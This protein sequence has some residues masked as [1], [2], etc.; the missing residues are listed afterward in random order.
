[1]SG[2]FDGFHDRVERAYQILR[3][4][5]TAFL[6][7][8][9]PQEQILGEAE[10]L[11]H[12]MTELKM[13]LKGV[14]FNRTHLECSM[15]RGLRGIERGDRAGADDLTAIRGIVDRALA[16]EGCEADDPEGAKALAEN[17]LRYQTIARGESLRMEA[18]TRGLRRGVPTTRVP[19]FPYDLHDIA[20]LAAM[21][22][23]LFAT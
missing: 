21:H 17:F 13:P 18:F 14:I 20:A 3:G 1:M 15:P 8:T 6:L 11:S 4:K 2:M 23:H 19:N 7:V 12:K 22:A 5:K 16:K 9:S 10:F